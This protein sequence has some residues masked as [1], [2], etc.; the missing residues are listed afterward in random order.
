MDFLPRNWKL[1][2]VVFFVNKKPNH[3]AECGEAEA[4]IAMYGTAARQNP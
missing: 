1:I 2:L 4:M 3:A